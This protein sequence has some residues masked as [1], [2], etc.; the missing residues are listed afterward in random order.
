MKSVEGDEVKMNK[1]KLP[2][3]WLA[4]TFLCLTLHAAADGAGKI[5]YE[6]NLEKAD[7]GKVPD[8]FLVLDGEFAVRES[9]G[10]KFLELPGAPLDTF[11]VLFG[12]TTNSG[13]CVSAR[14]FATGKG[15]RYPQ[16]GVGI[17]G[18]NGYKLKVS[19]AKDAVEIYSGDDAVATAAFHWKTGTWTMLKLQIRQTDGPAWKIE[20]KAWQQSETEPKEWTITLDEKTPPRAGRA[21]IWG[22]PIS[23]TPIRFDDLLLTGE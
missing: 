4:L 8:D 19:P 23:G 3:A 22:S 2:V 10:N 7:V 13:V 20:G 12:P 14:I 18:Q 5:L 9:E 15:R 17:N 21:S 1:Q 16:F 6:N 11:G